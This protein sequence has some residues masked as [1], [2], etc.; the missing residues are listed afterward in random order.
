MILTQRAMYKLNKFSSRCGYNRTFEDNTQIKGMQKVL[1]FLKI[2]V[3]KEG[4][5]SC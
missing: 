1:L 5:T 2:L 3:E 4:K